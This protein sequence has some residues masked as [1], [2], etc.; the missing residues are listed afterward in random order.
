MQLLRR[1]GE[2]DILWQNGATGQRGICSMDGTNVAGWADLGQVAL[3]WQIAMAADSTEDDRPDILWRHVSTGATGIRPMQGLQYAGGWHT[4]GQVPTS[5]SIAAAHPIARLFGG[6]RL[7]LRVG[8]HGRGARTAR[9]WGR[10]ACAAGETGG[11]LPADYGA[12]PALDGAST[13]RLRT[14]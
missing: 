5:W 10:R 13:M 14:G 1:G 3:E 8:T 12:A 7:L 11:C 9:R 4:L 6:G 2:S